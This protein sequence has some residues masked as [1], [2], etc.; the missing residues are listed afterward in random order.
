M[1]CLSVSVGQGLFKHIELFGE[2]LLRPEGSQSMKQI[3][4]KR[5]RVAQQGRRRTVQGLVALTP[6]FIED[7]DSD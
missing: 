5:K 1:V 4:G 6:E 2:S 3:V 7:S